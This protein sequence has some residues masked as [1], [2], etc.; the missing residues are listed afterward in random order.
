LIGAGLYSNLLCDFIKE[1]GKIAINC[2][3][4]IQLFFGLLGNRFMYLE[5]QNVTNEY[6]KYPDILKCIKYTDEKNIIF[7]G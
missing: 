7:N 1:Q 3:S 6:W 5:Q 4:S 2:G